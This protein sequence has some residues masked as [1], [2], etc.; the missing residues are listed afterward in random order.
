MGLDCG[1]G[2]EMAMSTA[3]AAGQTTCQGPSCG[4]RAGM[5]KALAAPA[6]A[7]GRSDCPVGPRCRPN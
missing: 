3:A 6:G 2:A 5:A 7:V 1:M 4:A